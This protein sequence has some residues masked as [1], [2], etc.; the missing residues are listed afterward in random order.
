MT[1]VA[2]SDSFVSLRTA[3]L[4]RYVIDDVEPSS[5]WCSTKLITFLAQRKEKRGYDAGW[6]SLSAGFFSF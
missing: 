5:C 1:E 4:I 3:A 6:V 2:A